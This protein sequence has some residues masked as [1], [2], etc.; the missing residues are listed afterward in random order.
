MA[1]VGSS[2]GN[3]EESVLS[4]YDICPINQKSDPSDLPAIAFT[5]WAILSVRNQYSVMFKTLSS[6]TFLEIYK[7]E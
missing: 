7:S 3:F 4:F 5:L 1:Y 2:E 6:E